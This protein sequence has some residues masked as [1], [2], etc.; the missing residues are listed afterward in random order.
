MANKTNLLPRMNQDLRIFQHN[1]RSLKKNKSELDQFLISENAHF[2][3]VTETWL[4]SD[5]ALSFRNYNFT[6]DTFHD[7]HGYG[8][9]GIL[10]RYDIQF[11]NLDLPDLFP[12]HLVGIKTVNLPKDF[13]LLSVY[14]PSKKQSL[15]ESLVMSQLSKLVSIIK[16]YDHILVS[17]DFNAHNLA[18]GSK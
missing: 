8:G 9:S 1:I 16:Q 17:G 6:H 12:I 13:I 4:L 5:H 10:S 14:V 7:A 18:W 11:D 15:D 3:L 2:Y